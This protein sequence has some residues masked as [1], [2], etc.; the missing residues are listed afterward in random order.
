MSE[1]I[2]V[3]SRIEPLCVKFGYAQCFAVDCVGRNGG[4][5]LIR[6]THVVSQVSG[7]SRN[8]IDLQ[9]KKNNL[10]VW[11]MTCFHGYPEKSHRKISRELIRR[12]ACIS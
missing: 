10:I 5:V 2:S 7:Y 8:H 9:F 11:R 3:G 12:L 1:T 6:K 4:L